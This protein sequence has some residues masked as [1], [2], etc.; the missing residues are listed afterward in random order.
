MSK[1]K[2]PAINSHASWYRSIVLVSLIILLALSACAP[3]GVDFADQPLVPTVQ[4]SEAEDGDAFVAARQRLTAHAVAVQELVD[5]DVI[6]ALGTVPRHRFVPETLVDR[7]YQDAPLPIGYGQTIS[8]PSLVALMTELLDLDPGDKVLEIG[9]GSG[10]QAAI[11]AELG[12]VSVYSIEIVPELYER[13]T[14][15]LQALGYTEV[16]TMAA[17]G[18]YGWEEFAPFDAIIVTAAPDHMPAPLADQLAEGGV[19][20]IPIGPQGYTQTLWK[21]V[22]TEG[23]LTA[24]NMGS[25]MFVP[26]T[27]EG[28]EEQ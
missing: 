25:V 18:Y 4:L 27:G 28:V 11:L 13:A 12:Y 17:D 14:N 8:Q 23:E 24:Y 2:K 6:R 26:F 5:E 1:D 22:K 9:T 21:F 19:M 20:V 3:A 10:Y 16:Q 7:A 15:V